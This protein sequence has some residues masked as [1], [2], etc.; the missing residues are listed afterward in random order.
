M[1]R[2]ELSI[3]SIALKRFDIMQT[4]YKTEWYKRMIAS[5]DALTDYFLNDEDIIAQCYHKI[6]TPD[7]LESLSRTAVNILAIGKKECWI[8]NARTPHPR[9]FVG[10]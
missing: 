3:H 9:H 6:P 2:L 7:L 4:S 1:T 10:T 8:I 5:M